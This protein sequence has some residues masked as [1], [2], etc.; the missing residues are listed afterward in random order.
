M[1]YV[2]TRTDKDVYTAHRVLCQKYGPDGGL[3]VPFRAPRFTPDQ[4]DGFSQMSFSDCV[5]QLLNIQF[6]TSLTAWDVDLAVGRYPVRLQKLTQRI[7]CVQCWHNTRGELDRMVEKLAILVAGKREEALDGD[8]IG[9]AVRIG[10]L[11]GIYGELKRAG[12]ASLDV[13]FDVSFVSGDFLGPVSALYAR[14]WGLPVGNVVCCCGENSSIWNFFSH[15]QLRMESNQ[16]SSCLPAADVKVPENLERM[17][18]GVS[19]E[20][21]TVR[22]AQ[23]VDSGASYYLPPHYLPSL[24]QGIH[25]S[26][27][28][29]TRSLSTL[30]NVYGS[31][32]FLLSPY[33]ALCYAGILDYRARTGSSGYAL[34]FSERS[35]RLDAEMIAGALNITVPEVESRIDRM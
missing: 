13:P 28:S 27:V 5:A 35:P 8:W 4:I 2:T 3:F 7:L 26:V 31:G 12:I 30:S 21:E 24:R 23:C 15:G 25:I 22:F 1:L 16:G 10:I 19:D 29:Q 32:G 14:S 9:I 11:F 6:H 17:I 20:E 33:D 34:I 18:H